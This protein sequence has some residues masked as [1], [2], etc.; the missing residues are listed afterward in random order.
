MNIIATVDGFEEANCVA[1][2][3][4]HAFVGDGG[5]IRIIDISVPEEAHQSYVIDN[6]SAK[7]IVA[8]ADRLYVL[9]YDVF[10]ILDISDLE[11]ISQL[12]QLNLGDVGI[13]TALEYI[14]GY[15]VVSCK[16]G[17]NQDKSI[18]QVINVQEPSYPF[19]IVDID[20]YGP[21]D[22]VLDDNVLYVVDHYS[23]MII[24]NLL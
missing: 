20:V 12:S 18:L 14:P 21:D 16:D 13:P 5:K 23:G 19:Q 4:N 8:T 7:E 3:D 17:S 11:N 24:C 10:F 1:L 2:T 9:G 15:C 6:V 22:I